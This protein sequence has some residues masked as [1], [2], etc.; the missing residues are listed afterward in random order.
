MRPTTTRTRRAP[1]RP[2]PKA[3]MRSSTLTRSPR[4]KDPRTTRSNRTTSMRDRRE[5]RTRSPRTATKD[6]RT[7]RTSPTRRTKVPS[8]RRPTR[9]SRSGHG[10]VGPRPA[11]R[12]S[13]DRSDPSGR[14]ALPGI[15]T[16]ALRTVARVWAGPPCDFWPP[17][18]NAAGWRD[19]PAEERRR[20]ED[21]NEGHGSRPGGADRGSVREARLIRF[22]IESQ[23]IEE[24][25]PPR[26]QEG[27]R[28]RGAEARRF[29]PPAIRREAR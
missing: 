11:E 17:P 19:A 9:R 18:A 26:F 5:R 28:G 14:N 2:R 27:R 25:R 4:T 13:V 7:T 24:P 12:R 3:T 1:T 21:P 29:Q 22:T 10:L 23:R 8:P 15:A 20:D 16:T 6:P